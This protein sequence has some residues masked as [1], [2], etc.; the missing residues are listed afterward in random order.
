MTTYVDPAVRPRP[1]DDEEPPAKRKDPLWAKLCLIL[2]ALVMIGSGALIIVPKLVANW[3]LDQVPQE[4]IIPEEL[5]GKNIEGDINLLLLGMDERKGH[6]DES[7][8]ADTIIIVHIPKTHDQIFMISLPR[9]AEVDIPDFPKTGFRGH[10]TKI[11][12]AFSGGAQK[13]GKPDNSPAGRRNGAELTMRTINDLVP[14]GLKFNGVVVINFEGF[15]EILKAIGGVRMCPSMEVRSIHFDKNDKYHTKKLDYDLRK[16]YKKGCQNFEYWEALDF[17]RQRYS[18]P[19]ADYTRQANQQLL[20]MAIFKKL[21]SKGTLTDPGKLLKL[22]QRA[23]DLL[24]LDLGQQEIID[25]IFTL[26]S[27]GPEDLVMIKTNGGR[28]NSI[29]NGNERLNETTMQ[30]LKAV[31]QDKVYDFVLKHPDWVATEKRG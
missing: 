9:D 23:G 20:L 22:Q 26:R 19:N 24:T 30:L 25:W 4:E 1:V 2:G 6:S 29:G 5:L 28:I 13:D 17:A 27:L 7:V 14:G 15:R 21:A 16:V 18:L 10:R 31:N 8:R 11:N 3:A 12:A